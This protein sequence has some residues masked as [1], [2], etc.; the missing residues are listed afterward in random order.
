M[1]EAT[2]DERVQYAGKGL[3]VTKMPIFCAPSLYK[4]VYQQY[5]INEV[6]IH[7]HY[8]HD[9]RECVLREITSTRE[10]DAESMALF[11][12]VDDGSMIWLAPDEVWSSPT[13]GKIYG[14]YRIES[15]G[16]K[17]L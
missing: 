6:T 15:D 3:P 2:A 5:G 17:W 8:L 16:P 1:R 4:R 7:Y 9:D 11:E 14:G 13:D 10:G 12:F